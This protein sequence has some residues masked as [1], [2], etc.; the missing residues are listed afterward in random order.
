MHQT[1]GKGNI[2]EHKQK[3]I[4][5]VSQL[6]A[7]SVCPCSRCHAACPRRHQP[8]LGAALSAGILPLGLWCWG[9]APPSKVSNE[10]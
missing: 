8:V 5:A 4:K 10:T 9:F 2:N 1:L 6:S 7:C 3:Q